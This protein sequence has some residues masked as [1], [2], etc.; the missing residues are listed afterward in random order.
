MLLY[1]VLLFAMLLGYSHHL[2]RWIAHSVSAEW[3]WQ[4]WCHYPH[5]RRQ[6]RVW[7][8][9]DFRRCSGLHHV[10]FAACQKLLFQRRLIMCRVMTARRLQHTSMNCW[11]FTPLPGRLTLELHVHYSL[12]LTCYSLYQ[13]ILLLCLTNRTV[14]NSLSLSTM[15]CSD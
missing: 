1:P 9:Q 6:L 13:T 7:Q 10:Q 15:R 8:G 4:C 14:L 3:Y 5:V 11:P 2:W 12:L